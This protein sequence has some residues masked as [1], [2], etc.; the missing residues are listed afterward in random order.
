MTKYLYNVAEHLLIKKIDTENNKSNIKT[1]TIKEKASIFLLL[2]IELTICF[3]LFYFWHE[4][5][6]KIFVSAL[7]FFFSGFIFIGIHV[8]YEEIKENMLTLHE[9]K[10]KDINHKIKWLLNSNI[11]F[12]SLNESIDLETLKALNENFKKEHFISILKKNMCN[13]ITYSNVLN[14]LRNPDEK[15][16]IIYQKYEHLKDYD[17]NKISIDYKNILRLILVRANNE[18]E[19]VSSKKAEISKEALKFNFIFMTPILGILSG[20]L[21]SLSKFNLET[22]AILLST[23]S[24]FSAIFILILLDF[25]YAPYAKYLSDQME[26]LNQ[27]KSINE[28]NILKKSYNLPFYYEQIDDEIYKIIVGSLDD[29]YIQTLMNN[30]GKITYNELF[31]FFQAIMYDK[32]IEDIY[33]EHYKK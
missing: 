30:E 26:S 15:H 10:N 16:N 28:K 19:T 29:I 20:L 18:K 22:H 32:I 2:A 13:E 6:E 21:Y 3:S 9:L 24:L 31:N 14:F 12:Y 23:I 27:F 4:I 11:N 33:Y 1:T 25:I 7:L 5:S 8:L 17:H